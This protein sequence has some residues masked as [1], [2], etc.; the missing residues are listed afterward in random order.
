MLFIPQRINGVG[1]GSLQGLPGDS[2]KG[3]GNRYQDG[4]RIDPPA[5]VGAVG[6]A[7]NDNLTTLEQ[8][9]DGGYI[10]AGSSD[11]DFWI[12]RTDAEG[13]MEWEK[14]L[15]GKGE[16]FLTTL[17]LLNDGGFLLG[18]YSDSN[19][20]RGRKK[21][22]NGGYDYRIVRTDQNGNALWERNLGGSSD[23]YLS[24]ALE[25]PNGGFLLGGYSCSEASA[26]KNEGSCG[27]YDY[28]IVS[29]TTKGEVI[30]ESTFGETSQDKL[31]SIQ[32]DS[33]GGFILSG[34][35]VAG[36]GA[37]SISHSYTRVIKID[38]AGNK[39]WEEQFGLDT[40]EYVE[41]T[42]ISPTSDFGFVL[43]G[44]TAAT[45]SGDPDKNKDAFTTD[46]FL[47]KHYSGSGM[48][49]EAKK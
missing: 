39:L 32:H 35:S 7:G 29:V 41:F 33:D 31:F 49:A 10:L 17:T 5:D 23:D 1:T 20:S 12:V 45:A 19:V 13:N 47:S 44:H 14:H 16:E 40:R 46:F 42:S 28:W 6:N 30:W 11:S 3:N 25:T 24:C 4:Q 15:G 26:D 21:R 43:L 27:G 2:G 38:A 34:N 37:R 22:S 48:F 8:A 9:P 18:G 36:N